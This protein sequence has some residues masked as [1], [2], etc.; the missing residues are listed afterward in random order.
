MGLFDKINEKMM[1]GASN[2]VGSRI[3]STIKNTANENRLVF[4]DNDKIDYTDKL[5]IKKTIN[6]D[7]MAGIFAEAQGGEIL[8]QVGITSDM[9]KDMLLEERNKQKGGK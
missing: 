5:G 9:V 7:A 2:I 8:A 6:L 3:K 1:G 4:L